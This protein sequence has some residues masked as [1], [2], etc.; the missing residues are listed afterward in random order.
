MI[1]VNLLA[2]SAG[3][4]AAAPAREWV[5]R[6]HRSALLGL[7]LLL[8]TVVGVGG[9]W[10]YLKHQLAQ[11]EVRISDGEAKLESL[12]D[13][14]R[15]L[16][17]ATNRKNELAERL[18]LIVRL[19]AAKRAPITLLETVSRNVPEGLW[20]VEIKQTG[21]TVQVDGRAISLT[22]VSDFAEGLQ[23]SG[24]FKMPVEIIATTTEIIDE[25]DV[26]RFSLKAEAATAPPP[27]TVVNTTPAGRPGV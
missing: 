15:L 2:T 6:E 12:K 3:G 20:L 26:I 1:R 22:S 8:V 13:A 18:A 4:G 16:E 17:A 23:R 14:V 5:P 27:T 21:L 9:W 10:W 11:A 25:N 19:R 7:G 24:L